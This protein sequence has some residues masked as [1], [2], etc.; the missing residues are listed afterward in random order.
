MTRS[1]WSLA[2]GLVVA[3]LVGSALVYGKLPDRVPTHWNLRGEVDGHGPRAVAAFLLPVTLVGL[4]GLLAVLPRLSP[5]SFRFDEFRSTY[6]KIVVIMLTMF[7]FV[8]TL[9]LLGALGYQFNMTRLVVAG[10]LLGLGLMGNFFGKIRR[11]FFVGVRVPWTLASER[12]WNETHRLAAWI[13]C[14]CGFT[15][16]LVALA[17]YPLAGLGFIVPIVIVP[18][19][20]SLVRYK[21]LEARGEV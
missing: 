9:A 18:I 3:V 19:V 16:S 12:V 21:Q 1:T 11:N 10:L 13:T 14:G 7:G 2:V 4:L 20:F 5:I 8:Q 15:G 6:G 17:G